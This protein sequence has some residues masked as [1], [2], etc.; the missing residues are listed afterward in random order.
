MQFWKY[1]P[2]RGLNHEM[3]SAGQKNSRLDV[4]AAAASQSCTSCVFQQSR[5]PSPRLIQLAA[6]PFT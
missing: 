1:H 3:Y 5:V 2:S 6:I 4:A